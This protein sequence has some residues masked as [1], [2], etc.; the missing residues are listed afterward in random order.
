MRIATTNLTRLVSEYWRRKRDLTLA[1][2]YCLIYISDRSI[3]VERPFFFLR[4]TTH[5]F[6]LA[7]LRWLL[8]ECVIL[9]L[10][11]WAIRQWG[12]PVWLWDL[13]G[14]NFLSFKNQQSEVIKHCY[15]IQI[16]CLIFSCNCNRLSTKERSNLSTTELSSRITFF[17]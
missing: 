11:Y 5:K 8:H 10:F 17:F 16:G 4:L 9:S 13:W 15:V 2:S 7:Y 12:N 6:P 14:M 3:W 1:I